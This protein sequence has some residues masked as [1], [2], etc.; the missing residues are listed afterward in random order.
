MADARAL[1]LRAADRFN[2][3]MHAI[4]PDDWG[5]PTPCA[6]WDVRTLVDHLVVE[7]LWI[8]PLLD[9]LT[10]AD[11]GDR[12]DGDML[13]EDP[14]RSWDAAISDA[15]DAFSAYPALDQTVHLSFGDVPAE[16]YAWQMTT[17]LLIHGW[18]L[19]R[20]IGA[21]ES[22][23]DELVREIHDKTVPLMDV[24]AASGMFA[25]PVET[26]DDASP[27]VQLLALFG[28]RA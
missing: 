23:D 17:D 1:Y 6:D 22:M 19:A 27:S 25:P 5:R 9:G 11:V 3:H 12:F 24:L 10:I 20:G 21:D 7:Q 13:G 4:K 2:E 16:E 8:P 14:V 26:D 28:R 18:D 15:R